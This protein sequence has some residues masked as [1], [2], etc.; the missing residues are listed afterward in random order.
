MLCSN[1]RPRHV[2]QTSNGVLYTKS[3]AE[4]GRQLTCDTELEDYDVIHD[5]LYENVPDNI[6]DGENHYEQL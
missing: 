4:S 5:R 1:R 6:A 3:K 2:Y